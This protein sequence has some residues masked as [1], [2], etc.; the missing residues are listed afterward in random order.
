MAVNQG[1]WIVQREGF[2]LR[3]FTQGE[4][5]V[6]DMSKYVVSV[7]V[8]LAVVSLLV[9]PGVGRAADERP[10]KT[11]STGVG[12]EELVPHPEFPAKLVFAQRVGNFLANVHVTIF[13]KGNG[14]EKKIIDTTSSG[15]WFFANL[16]DGRY[17]VKATFE[18]KSQGANFSVVGNCQEVVNLAWPIGR[19]PGERLSQEGKTVSKVSLLKSEG[20]M[21][22]SGSPQCLPVKP[23]S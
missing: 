15:P 1:E 6:M 2:L 18:G 5:G 13:E 17:Y 21:G 9:V 19:Q 3:G 12:M 11:L 16:P 10:L 20:R 22:V 8:T 4:K 23:S 7:W 14:G